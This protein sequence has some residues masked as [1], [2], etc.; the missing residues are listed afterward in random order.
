MVLAGREPANLG[1]KGQHA[2]LDH[3]SHSPQI[4]HHSKTS[5][6]IFLR[7]CKEY[8][9]NTV[10]HEMKHLL[11]GSSTTSIH[12]TV[13]LFLGYL[14][15]AF[16]LYESDS[17]S[18]LLVNTVIR[19]LTCKNIYVVAMALCAS[20]HIIPPDQMVVLLPVL[21]EKLKHPNVSIL[22]IITGFV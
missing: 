17:L 12:I 20:C 2:T 16:L 3:R 18:V 1:T 5:D 22:W 19:D 13:S 7:S 8:L 10:F 4:I 21:Q 11:N 9:F 6:M 15:C 14:A